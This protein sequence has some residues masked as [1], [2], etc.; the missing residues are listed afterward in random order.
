MGYGHFSQNLSYCL[1]HFI[2]KFCRMPIIK[3]N[4]KH[5]YGQRKIDYGIDELI[6]TCVV[7]NGERYIKSFIEHHF[8]LGVKHIVFLDNGSTDDTTSI[9]S[10]YKNVTVL[11]AKC[12]YRK[13]ETS[14]KEYLVRRFSTNRWNLFLDIDE[15]F[16]YPFSENLD[17]KALLNYLNQHS[18]TA[19]IAQI[20]DLFSEK[21]LT[22]LKN[23]I[24]DNLKD[25]Y[26]YYDISNIKKCDY[27]YGK[28]SNKEV[29][30][31]FGGIRK[32]IFGSNN[33]LTKAPLVFIDHK[34]KLFVR[35]HHAENACLADFTCVLL[36]YPFISSFSEKV[37]EAVK[38]DRYSHSTAGGE[39]KMYWKRVQ[40]KPDLNIKQDA[41]C[42]LENLSDLVENG[43]LVVSPEY[44]QYAEK[45]RPCT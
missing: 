16:D 42:K 7:R 38:T 13:Y 29:K 5:L 27:V 18:Y 6:A 34:I 12:P 32:T 33:G 35:W 8:A 45:K 41:A 21:S 44:A 22:S 23:A 10:N 26:N 30:M 39:Y 24:N 9:A 28:L 31:H 11:Q 37:K 36:H 17:L 3:L 4:V 43:F 19:A 15:L 25:V 14:L 1:T 20:L 40:I 2:D